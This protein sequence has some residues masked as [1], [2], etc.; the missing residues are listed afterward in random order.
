MWIVVAIVVLAALC[1]LAWRLNPSKTRQH[2]RLAQ[3]DAEG[4]ARIE[5]QRAETNM[6]GRG[7]G[8][9]GGGTGF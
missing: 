1:F 7:A 5:M 9:T 3:H 4:A 8:G 6:R 2:D